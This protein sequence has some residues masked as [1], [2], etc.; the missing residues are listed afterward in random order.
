MTRVDV[1]LERLRPHV[2]RFLNDKDCTGFEI[3]GR[4]NNCEDRSFSLES[5]GQWHE[6]VIAKMRERVKK[7]ARLTAVR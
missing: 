1:M 7:E 4:L 5:K 2:E 6:D 3:Y